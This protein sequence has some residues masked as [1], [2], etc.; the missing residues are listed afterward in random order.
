MRKNKSKIYKINEEFQELIRETAEKLYFYLS[1][2][3]ENKL[4]DVDQ[5]FEE[6][7]QYEKKCDR[8]KERYIE[9]LFKDKRA[10]PFLLEDR[11]K[12]VI[13]LDKIL[14]RIEFI[15]RF[16]EVYPFKIYPEISEELNALN[17]L[18]FDGIVQLM[19]CALLME[20][21]FDAAYQITFEVEKAR[22]QAHDVKF[23]ILDV[24]Y[25][26]KEEPLRIQLTAKLITLIYDVTQ[27]VEEISD[28]LRGLI[29]KYPNR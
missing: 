29:I 27:W 6:I 23:K 22:R 15:A 16:M 25:Q 19:N 28:F 7:I 5:K 2:Y 9:T 8:I 10:L 11:Y 3:I 21:N 17:K 12:L 20:T 1:D 4:G 18:T 24:I 26:K 14:N 13:S